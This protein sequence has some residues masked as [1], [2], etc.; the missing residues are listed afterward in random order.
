MLHED[1]RAFLSTKNSADLMLNRRGSERFAVAEDQ[2]WLGW[3]EGRIFRK[4]PA[5]L[6]DIS[7]GGAKLTVEFSPPRRSTVWVCLEGPRQTAWVEG[8]MLDAVKLP[9]GHAEIRMAFREVCPY[10]FFE[11]AV[12]GDPAASETRSLVG[13]VAESGRS[14]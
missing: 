10:S 3:W 2:A 5:T 11:V 1:P 4:T 12:F 13:G 6:L 7:Q 9:D 8:V 14:Y